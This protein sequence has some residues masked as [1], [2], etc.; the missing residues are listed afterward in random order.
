MKNLV[1]SKQFLTI[2]PI[3]IIA[4]SVLSA[5]PAV[6]SYGKEQFQTTFSFTCSASVSFCAG[7]GFWGWCAFGG[8]GTTADCQFSL[9][10]FNGNAG[11]PP[12]GVIHVAQDITAWQIGPSAA[13]PPSL[14]GF[15]ADSGTV[16]F[17]GPGAAQIGLPTGVDL[18]FVPLC[19]GGLSFL[20]D[21]GIPAVPGHYT[22]NQIP[23]FP[24]LSQQPGLRFNVQVTKIG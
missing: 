10:N 21:T 3:S 9:Y 2:L 1:D 22:Y 23:I 7:F 8:G 13:L 17:S 4:I 15:L 20:C 19:S 6:H 11:F 14:P 16:E 18:N 24:S 12:F 5:V